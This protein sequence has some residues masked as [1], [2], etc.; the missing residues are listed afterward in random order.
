MDDPEE[1]FTDLYDR[2]YRSVLG[3]ALLRAERDVAEDVSSETFLVAW[4][5]LGDLPESPLPWLLGVARNLLAKQR[6]SRH[7]RQALVD[8][9][10]A[11]TTSRDQESWDVAEHV[12]DRESAMAALSALPEQD[13]EA[14]VFATWYG[15]PPEQAAA[16]MGCSVRTYNVRLHR[17][18]K[19][20]TQALR[21]GGAVPRP[22]RTP[23]RN[24]S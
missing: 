2:H 13:V 14:M 15:L 20:L 24:P 4:R 3:Y 18:R 5:R 6:D 16:V 23:W 8:R 22:V 1:R 9:I 7:R 10:A 21:L 12:I 19:R 17:A 11:L